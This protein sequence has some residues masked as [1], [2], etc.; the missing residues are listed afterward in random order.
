[1][2]RGVLIWPAGLEFGLKLES[3]AAGLVFPPTFL[4]TS[5]RTKEKKSPEASESAQMQNA[6]S[7]TSGG[8]VAEFGS[9]P[10]LSGFLLV[11]GLGL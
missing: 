1:M 7:F 10:V 4:L 3:K 2:K 6:D 11:P 9:S 8:N 5:P